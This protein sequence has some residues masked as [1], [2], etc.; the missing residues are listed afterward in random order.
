MLNNDPMKAS[1]CQSP[2]SMN[3]TFHGQRDFAEESKLRVL[4]WRDYPSGLQVIPY[5]QPRLRSR[6]QERADVRVEAEVRQNTGA[7]LL[8]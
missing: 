5:K 6:G 1:T 3:V 2:E 8:A 7:M 4:V